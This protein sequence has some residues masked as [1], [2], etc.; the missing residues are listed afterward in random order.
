MN[1][2]P[3]AGLPP[4][5]PDS[6]H[7]FLRRTTSVHVMLT[8]LPGTGEDIPNHLKPD[9]VDGSLLQPMRSIVVFFEAWVS[10]GTR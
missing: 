10:A 6:Y 3:I 8:L 7:Y 9:P 5:T 2:S 1:S 4:L